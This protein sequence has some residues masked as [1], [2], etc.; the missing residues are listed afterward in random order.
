MG[1]SRRANIKSSRSLTEQRA[2]L[3]STDSGWD[4]K[5]GEGDRTAEKERAGERDRQKDGKGKGEKDEEREAG[6]VEEGEI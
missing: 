2:R 4:R 3:S 6:E 5:L 1:N